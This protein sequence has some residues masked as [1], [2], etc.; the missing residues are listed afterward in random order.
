VGYLC[1]AVNQYFDQQIHQSDVV[2]SYAGVRPLLDD[3]IINSS[4][5]TRDYKLEV[6]TDGAPMMSIYGG[7]I[8]TYR[9]LAEEALTKLQPLI[10]IKKPNWT[11]RDAP[12]P[13]GDIKD[14]DFLGFL[15][16]LQNQ[17]PLLPDEL[18][19]RYA[20]SYGTRALQILGDAKNLTDLGEGIGG[21]LYTAELD[22]LMDNEWALTE[23]D[24][25]WRRSKLGLSISSAAVSKLIDWLKDR[26]PKDDIY[27]NTRA[28]Q[29]GV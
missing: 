3:E 2:W 23:E 22:Y 19:Q 6:D 1:D 18:I 17:Y 21:G 15:S 28:E 5:V 13:G 16:G 25:L 11:H 14:V 27:P 24:I 9:K 26:K 12:L 4:A 8:T 7:K 20:R 29:V 10:D